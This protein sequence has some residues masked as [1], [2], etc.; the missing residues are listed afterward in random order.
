MFLFLCPDQEQSLRH[1]RNPFLNLVPLGF[2]FVGSSVCYC[3]EEKKKKKEKKEKEKEKEKER[4]R[5]G[6]T[7]HCT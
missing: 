6:E 3:E 7:N 4:E 2:S 1:I 5:K